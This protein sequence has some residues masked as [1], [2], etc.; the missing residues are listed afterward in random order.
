[1][2]DE[3]TGNWSIGKRLIWHSQD[4]NEV[5]SSITFSFTAY[6]LAPSTAFNTTVSAMSTCQNC[7][8]SRVNQVGNPLSVFTRLCSL[9]FFIFHMTSHIFWDIIEVVAKKRLKLDRLPIPKRQ[10]SKFF[11]FQSICAWLV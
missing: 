10:K 5:T 8:F 2:C 3:Y 4:I 1:M 6:R 11:N 7:A 9:G